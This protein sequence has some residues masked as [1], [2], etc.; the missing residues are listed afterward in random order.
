MKIETLK[1]KVIVIIK[2][3]R[4]ISLG[5]RESLCKQISGMNNEEFKFFKSSLKE[6][7]RIE[8]LQARIRKLQDEESDSHRDFLEKTT[9][10]FRCFMS[11]ESKKQER[12]DRVKLDETLNR[13]KDL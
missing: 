1:E 10:L 4:D 9:T 12:A 7:N 2:S 11:Q 5:L 3:K 8:N 6:G 13:I